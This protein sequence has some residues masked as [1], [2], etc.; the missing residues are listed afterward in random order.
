MAVKDIKAAIAYRP[1]FTNQD[2]RYV[3]V[4]GGT[5][6]GKSYHMYMRIVSRILSEK[7]HI[8]LCLRKY[9]TTVRRSIWHGLT[10]YIVDAG[11][12]HRFT[13][14]RGNYTI[15]CD[16]GN[17]IWM[18]GVDDPEKLKS[19]EGV[20]SVWLEEATAF[21]ASDFVELDRRFY[22]DT[23]HHKEILITFNPIS[24][25]NWIYSLFFSGQ[26]YKDDTLYVHTTLAD[27]PWAPPDK[28]KVV[29]RY[30]NT[31]DMAYRVYGLGE[32]GA[33]QGLIYH[34]FAIGVAPDK[35]PEQ[36][37]YGLDFGY[38]VPSALIRVDVHDGQ[39]Y[40]SELL[41]QTEMTAADIIAKI[42]ASEVERHAPIYCDAADPATIEAI[43][44]AGYNAKPAKKDVLQGISHIKSLH[45]KIVVTDAPNLTR[46]AGLYRWQVDK[47]EQPMDRPVK[48]ED[49]ALDALRYALYTHLYKG[50]GVSITFNSFNPYI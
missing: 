3:V 46:E 7:P 50:G 10:K 27:N 13:F 17:E 29:E 33:L 43:H 19:I 38:N 40:V 32:W 11:L 16:N 37:F 26:E 30:K 20:T 35:R 6:S 18:G 45:D 36:T 28:L 5:G 42:K 34:P 15:V 4:R 25:N 31:D 24:T 44:R 48:S 23:P 14:Y 47:D 2:K 1:I 41:Y 8:Y 12:S 21:N 22:A 39:Y 9:A 49:H